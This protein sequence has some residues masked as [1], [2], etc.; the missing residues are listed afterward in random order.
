M[1]VRETAVPNGQQGNTVSV[2]TLPL[3]QVTFFTVYISVSPSRRGP[4]VHTP[5]L[6]QGMENG[7]S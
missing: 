5:P 2:H 4:Q 6:E 1:G 7:K 3:P